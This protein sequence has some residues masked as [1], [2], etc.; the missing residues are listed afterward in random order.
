[1]CCL[2]KLR[3]PTS[4]QLTAPPFP[5]TPLFPPPRAEAPQAGPP[6]PAAPAAG[7]YDVKTLSPAVRKLVE[8]N[9]LDP[10]KIKPTGK[11]GRLTKEDVQQAIAAGRS[12]EH[13]SELQ[14]RMRM[15]YAGFCLKKKK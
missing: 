3:R 1:M 7:T 8:D 13:T 15:S 5:Y 12:E 10:A 2:L 4:S 14:S 11:D 9:D 6:K